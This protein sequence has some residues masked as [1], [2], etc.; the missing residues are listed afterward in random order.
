VVAAPSANK[1]GK[2]SP[3]KANHVDF[4]E[5]EIDMIVNGGATKV[6]LESTVVDVTGDYPRIL[7]PGAITAKMIYE[8]TGLEPK[9][10]GQAE[11][12]PRSPGM[13]YRHYAPN[14]PMTIISGTRQEVAEHMI[15]E[16]LQKVAEGKII[17]LLVTN[18]TRELI[19]RGLGQRPVKIS[20]PEGS[21]AGFSPA[22]RQDLEQSPIN[23]EATVSLPEGSVAG[24]PPAKRQDLEQSPINKEATVS[25]PEGSVAGVPPAERR[26]FGGRAPIKIITF[27]D[28]EKIIARN[29]FACL[30]QFNQLDVSEI[31]AEAVPNTGLGEAIMNRMHKAAGGRVVNVEA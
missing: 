14:A 16:S 17:G 18:S 11:D 25:L 10:C 3:T 23:K 29:L 7:R 31:Y 30:R 26:G 9:T 2:P 4:A 28:E 13:K 8:T 27:G 19:Q 6:G 1:A 15:K 21:V 24:V 20:L 22:K 12:T 5:N